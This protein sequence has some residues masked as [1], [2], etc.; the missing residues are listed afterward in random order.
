MY[1]LDTVV[2]SELR[3]RRT[4][5]KLAAWIGSVPAHEIHLSVLTIAEIET[6]IEQQKKVN[7]TFAA[8][9]ATWQAQTMVVYGD[10]VLPLTAGIGRRW[11]RLIAQVGHRGFD[12]GIAAT[13]LEHGLTVITRN[14]TDFAPTGA[15]T[16]NPFL[17]GLHENHS[18]FAPARPRR[19]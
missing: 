4:D 11:G 9:L 8:E 3:K 6:G 14:I 1:L 13:A 10:R 12:L 5:P 17:H 18:R 2:V 15:A 16:L 19:R 7:P